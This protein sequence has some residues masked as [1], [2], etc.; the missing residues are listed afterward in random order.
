MRLHTL[1]S[2]NEAAAAADARSRELSETNSR[3]EAHV[4]VRTCKV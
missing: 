3:L 1:Q 2:L 4:Q